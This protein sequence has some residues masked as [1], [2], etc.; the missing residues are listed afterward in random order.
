MLRQR[1]PGQAS[2]AGSLSPVTQ[3]RH[4]RAPLPRASSHSD[5]G[6]PPN[7]PPQLRPEYQLNVR[8]DSNLDDSIFSICDSNGSKGPTDHLLRVRQLLRLATLNVVSL[9]KEGA[10]Q[11]LASDLEHAG[12][13][14]CGLQEVR[15]RGSGKRKVS[16]QGWQ[17]V[18]SG[19]E[20]SQRRGVGAMLS[21][22]ASKALKG[23]AA[24]SDRLMTLQFCGQLPL[25]VVVAYAPT[26]P[27]EAADKDTFYAKLQ[28]VIST[29][30]KHSAVV[31]LGDMNAQLGRD[32]AAWPGVLGAH[33]GPVKSRAPWQPAPAPG[34]AQPLATHVANDNG[35]RCLSLCSGNRL[36]VAN[37]LFKHGDAHTAS[38]VSNTGSYQATL[39]HIL[40]TRRLRTSIRDSRV[41][42]GAATSVQ[43]DHRLVT[44]D[45]LLRLRAQRP[46]PQ[47]AQP[48]FN[49]AALAA[50]QLVQRAYNGQLAQS[51]LAIT[52]QH[53]QLRSSEAE[54]ADM[55]GAVLKAA[56]THLQLPPRNASK[57]YLSPTTLQLCEA[58]AAA[59]GQVRALQ[60]AVP[61]L[62]EHPSPLQH[63]AWQQAMAA[64]RAA[65]AQYAQ[66]RAR[67]K[68][69]CRADEQADA[70]RLT[71]QLQSDMR[72]GRLQQA[73]KTVGKLAGDQ[74]PAAI[75]AVATP[76]GG[77][78]YGEQVAATLA[79]HF[80][81][82][83]NVQPNAVV[84]PIPSEQ[85]QLIPGSP[86]PAARPQA[87]G[88]TG[89]RDPAAVAAAAQVPG[90]PRVGEAAALASSGAEPTCAEVHTAIRHLCNT[91]A[92]AN[93][94][95]APLLKHGISH[96]TALLHRVITSA[97]RSGTA[98]AAWKS[99]VLLPL[100]KK[101]DKQQPSNYRPISLLDVTGKVYVQILH[102]RMRGHLNSLLMD[103]QQGFRPGR[104]T[105]DALFSMRRVAELARDFGR[106]LHAAFVDLKAA[107]D[108]VNR[109][110]LWQ[111]LLARGIS[112]KLVSLVA[113]LYSGC[114]AS[115]KANG[116]TS[117][118]FSVD[119]GVRQGCPMSP[120]LFNTF[121]DFVARL[122]QQQCEAQG[123]H[124]FSFAFRINGQL[125]SAPAAGDSV[126]HLLMLLYADD[127]VLM[128]QDAASLQL[129]LGIF[130]ATAAAWGL[131]LNHGKTKVVVF[132]QPAQQPQP[133]G[134]VQLAHG[135]VECTRDFQY[136]GS[137]MQ[138]DGSQQAEVTRRLQQASWVFGRL[139]PKLFSSRHVHQATKLRIYSSI[140]QPTLLY[141]A[142]ES[143]ALNFAQAR[144]LNSFHTSRLRIITGQHF[145]GPDTTPNSQLFEESR[146]RPMTATLR[147]HR[148]RW[149]GHMAR[150]PDTR[151][152]KQLLFATSPGS[153]GSGAR[154]VMGGPAKTWNRTALE[155]LRELGLEDGQW[156]RVCMDRGGWE[157]LISQG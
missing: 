138:A 10:P 9:N 142:A 19:D 145:A 79:T 14:I 83:L 148:L 56:H 73:Y 149:L 100:F 71:D 108:S 127:L 81:A 112:P 15:W 84:G 141:G 123:V 45:L 136:L 109:A 153:D 103:A 12:V 77:I 157:A 49:T 16:D 40:V 32:T 155:S 156:M 30:P 139:Q 52:Y 36:V 128:A 38:F 39:D 7:G 57:P 98:P 28:D 11:Q 124:G 60:A 42:P 99:A 115:V 150:M 130:E 34:A 92:G 41:R 89:P 78:A 121:M 129:A 1:G 35:R 6:R 88:R 132:G 18:W 51:V 25:T 119:T 125:H 31:V 62:P 20:G 110:A 86:A 46:R 95:T 120:T 91:A 85:L 94:I 64:L 47:D 50:N 33:S 75:T 29:I 93:G 106:P 76:G 59:Y 135:V 61:E 117:A 122:V 133:G 131:Q 54:Y 107:F 53:P 96:V 104:G 126:A 24:I 118:P 2:G 114:Q 58:K 17:F 116:T 22:L 147:Q 66:W 80:S 82:A 48:R 90:V 152:P 87:G 105:G 68:K 26:N 67:V 43:S 113:D 101:G 111:L 72:H 3:G 154:R 63:V 102:S 13:H 146:Q 144:E 21:P 44:C 137:L 143:W 23:F 134:T 5:C 69:A 151:L 37:S 74:P 55:V 70:K 27:S 4:Q 140:V 8:T 65:E 97:W